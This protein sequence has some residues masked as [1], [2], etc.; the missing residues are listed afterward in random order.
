MF[1]NFDRW[2]DGRRSDWNTIAFDSSE[3]KKELRMVNS[4][5][6]F[7]YMIIEPLICDEILNRVG[8]KFQKSDTNF[9]SALGPGIRD[10][11]GHPGS[12]GAL[13]R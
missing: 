8:S 10:F 7:H 2:T 4:S 5:S 3:L 1:E 11:N 9:R 6:F 13:K 12:C